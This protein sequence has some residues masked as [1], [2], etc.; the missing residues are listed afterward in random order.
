[1]EKIKC[2]K[3]KNGNKKYVFKLKDEYLIEAA[4]FLHNEEVHLCIPSQ[5]GCMMKCRHCAT[6]YVNPSF[7]R[8]LEYIEM[9]EMI[10]CLLL[11]CEFN[12]QLYTLSFSGHGEPMCNWQCIVNVIKRYKNIFD[13]IDVT[14][15]GIKMTMKQILDGEVTPKFFF[16]IHGSNNESR[17]WIV[18][19]FNNGT[20]ASIEEITDFCKH[21]VIQKGGT[22]TWN[23]MVCQENMTL[24]TISELITL[25]NAIDFPLE[26]RFT[27]Y[28]N[29]YKDN[30]I[31]EIAD[32]EFEKMFIQISENLKSN[33]IVRRSQ[34]EGIETEI[35]CGQMR[36]R[37]IA[38]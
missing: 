25:L 13:V 11:E 9:V 1:M 21:Y 4:V 10:D 31:H 37:I 30:G 23:Y 8:Q 24:D 36:A 15:I 6:T 35:A 19:P 34:L 18:N 3:D 2:I 14:S 26:L 20:V 17:R 32:S 16:S 27:K 28:V 5:V 7:F 12:N 29:I 22:C 38:R 33:I